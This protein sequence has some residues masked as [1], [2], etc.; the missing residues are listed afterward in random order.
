M[1][2]LMADPDR[3]PPGASPARSL[4]EALPPVPN[5]FAV[6]DLLAPPHPGRSSNSDLGADAELLA[7]ALFALNPPDASS[8]ADQ[9]MSEVKGP[10]GDGAGG[11]L[12]SEDLLSKLLN[13][14]VEI[15]P[16]A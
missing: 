10:G 9:T 1:V 6:D 13:L 15:D 16:E 14:P 7:A 2:Q 3:P 4:A 8:T 5:H 11:Q 12:I